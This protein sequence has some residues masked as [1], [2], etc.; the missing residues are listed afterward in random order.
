MGVSWN[1]LVSINNRYSGN[2]FTVAGSVNLRVAVG[3][4]ILKH[5][6]KIGDKETNWQI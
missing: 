5:L 4:L 1:V 3:A 6:C 2:K